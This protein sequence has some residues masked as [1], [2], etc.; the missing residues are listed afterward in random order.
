MKNIWKLLIIP[1]TDESSDSVLT[2]INCL[3][4][5]H[6]EKVSVTNKRKFKSLKEG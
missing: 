1:T 3:D 5:K 4:I 6:Q 2:T